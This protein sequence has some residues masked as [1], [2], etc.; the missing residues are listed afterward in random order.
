M[1]TESETYKVGSRLYAVM[2]AVETVFGV[3]TYRLLGNETRREIS[4]ARQA[5]FYLALEGLRI[6]ERD[7][8][9]SMNR[10]RTTSYWSRKVAEDLIDALPGY[11]AKVR[12]AAR[13]ANVKI[14]PA[15][16]GN[17]R[18]A[19]EQSASPEET[20]DRGLASSAVNANVTGDPVLGRTS[21]RDGGRDRTFRL[22]F[23]RSKRVRGGRT[24]L[25][26]KPKET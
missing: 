24:W 22:R 21:E 2:R 23:A 26:M 3:P 1:K 12:E 7:V 15:V 5:V 16:G 4:E 19:A 8:A 10:D 20:A 14:A 9:A 17:Q 11:A 6:P 13:I 25:E 18:S